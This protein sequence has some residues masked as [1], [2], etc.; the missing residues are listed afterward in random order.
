MRSRSR[1]GT[2]ND[3]YWEELTST[4]RKKKAAA[5]AVGCIVLA[6]EDAKLRI[7]VHSSCVAIEDKNWATSFRFE[8]VRTVP[9]FGPVPKMDVP[10]HTISEMQSP[11][12]R[13]VVLLSIFLLLLVAPFTVRAEDKPVHIG[14][15]LDSLKIERWQ[16][17]SKLI[18]ARARE[19]NARVTV[20]DAEG[21]D[22][23]Q[24]QQANQLLDE[25][26]NVLI[27]VPHDADKAASIVQAAQ[28]KG[29]PVV[30]Y[31]RLIKNSPASL[32]ISFDNVQV[33]KLQASFL[34]AAAPR[35][36]YLLLQG[37]TTDNNA[38]QLERGQKLALEQAIDTNRININDEVWCPQWSGKEGYD[39]TVA[40]LK[41]SGGKIAAIVAAN[42]EIAG[43][44]IRALAERK[45]AGTVPVSG[46][47]ADLAAVVRIIRGTQTITVYK[48]LGPLA[49][50]AVDAAVRLARGAGPDTTEKITNG[51]YTVP[52]ILLQPIA[53]DRKNLGA[54]VILD[55]FHPAE[56]IKKVL[57]SG[58]W[59]KF[60]ARQH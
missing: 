32:Y 7:P 43:G 19:L 22:D 9:P 20:K 44:A 40:A 33:G 57:A 29:V 52:A 18:Q 60:I 51:A 11:R 12:N 39:A 31:D 36:N 28:R 15:L 5:E 21:N 55:G 13:A 1:S 50:R 6:S 16:R 34:L 47:D 8:A 48:P 2:D 4:E 45:L 41:K 38:H 53:V 30:S 35:G 46:Q 49:K 26:V 24:L 10:V 3:E 27:V 54:T 25:G 23:L 56:E 42:D 17:D 59:E 14:L 58:E 37:A